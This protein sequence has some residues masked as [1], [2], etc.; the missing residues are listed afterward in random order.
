M[1]RGKSIDLYAKIS[2]TQLYLIIN[3]GKVVAKLLFHTTTHKTYSEFCDYTDSATHVQ[4]FQFPSS[5]PIT[6]CLYGA[7]FGENDHSKETIPTNWY[8]FFRKKGY[9]IISL[10][11]S[12]L[13]TD[14]ITTLSAH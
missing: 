5:H 11:G 13:A 10:L 7:R 9:Q 1:A 6:G 14:P 3:E 8:T 12:T 4:R 2:N